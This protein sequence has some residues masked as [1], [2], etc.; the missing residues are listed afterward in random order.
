MT[1]RQRFLIATAIV[2]GM[3]GTAATAPAQTPPDVVLT[4]VSYDPTRELYRALSDAF[5]KDWQASN[6]QKV[7]IRPPTADRASRP[8]R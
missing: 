1:T 4:N 3:M 8:V 2:L 5:T 7:T 6:H